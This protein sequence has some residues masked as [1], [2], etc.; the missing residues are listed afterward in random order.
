M[1][2][3]SSCTK[4]SFMKGFNKAVEEEHELPQWKY[5]G[6]GERTWVTKGLTYTGDFSENTLKQGKIT[7]VDKTMKMSK[8]YYSLTG[9]ELADSV[10]GCQFVSYEGGLADY[11]PHGQGRL[12]FNL[13][14][15][16]YVYSGD[17]M[18][19]KL[20]NCKLWCN[21]VLQYDG[22]VDSNFLQHSQGTQTSDNQ[23]WEGEFQHGRFWTGVVTYGV[24]SGVKEKKYVDGK[25][26]Q[27]DIIT[28]N[29]GILTLTYD[30]TGNESGLR[31][32]PMTTTSSFCGKY[33]C[34]ATY[35]YPSGTVLVGTWYST[36]KG[37]L[38]NGEWKYISGNIYKGRFIN[39]LLEGWGEMTDQDGNK[40]IGN[41]RNGMRWGEGTLKDI[42]GEIRY[43]GQ[44][45][46][47]R[48]WTA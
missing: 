9:C 11:V 19:G 6:V 46:E 36:N 16:T 48:Q 47:D 2:A 10:A 42:N 38:F 14:G 15:K 8:L 25:C 23:I 34:Q 3:N 37:S 31:E 40:Y 7:P 13:N 33:S 20:N 32:I 21:E 27:T 22:G 17:F 30:V 45:V 4:S 18:T 43:A 5:G 29:G 24:N 1:G 28:S 12:T 44:W 39:G 26:T 41:F 35:K